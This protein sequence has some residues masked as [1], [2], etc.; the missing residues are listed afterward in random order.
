M[1]RYP[2]KLASLSLLVLA[3]LLTVGSGAAAAQDA[4]GAPADGVYVITID[5]I[6][7]PMSA[8]YLERGL[9]QSR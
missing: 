3:L 9:R 7:N 4:P 5:G 1:L 2:I 6:I 8:N